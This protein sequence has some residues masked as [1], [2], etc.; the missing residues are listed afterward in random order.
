MGP[1][2]GSS[3]TKNLDEHKNKENMPDFYITQELKI[4]GR[5]FVDMKKMKDRDAFIDEKNI[6]KELLSKSY[7]SLNSS[8]EKKNSKKLNKK[9]RLKGPDFRKTITRERLDYINS[10]KRNIIPFT[11]PKYSATRGS[12]NY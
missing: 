3:V 4:T 2:W 11:I 6:S 12:K 10:D 5:N 9:P 7:L 1:E 8:T